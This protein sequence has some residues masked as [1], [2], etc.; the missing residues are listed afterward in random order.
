ML[1]QLLNMTDGPL[2]DILSSSGLDEGPNTT[3]AIKDTLT[4][5]LQKKAQSGD[6]SA[7]KEM[8][9]GSETTPSSP[10]VASLAGDLS[11]GLMDRLGISKEKALSMAMAVLPM[12][13]NFFNK[14]VD[15]APMS[16][17]SIGDTIGDL[18]SGK[19]SSSATDLLGSLLGGSGGSGLGGLMDM[20]KGLFK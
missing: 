12:L 20:G 15:D 19:G 4:S 18:L 11:G 14:K 7:I 3:N 2:K 9:S 6:L 5:I 8:F 10:E 16:N 13:M 17:S 1:D